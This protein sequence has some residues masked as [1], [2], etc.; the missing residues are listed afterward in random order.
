MLPTSTRVSLFFLLIPS[1]PAE[2]MPWSSVWTPEFVDESL[3][4]LCFHEFCSCDQPYVLR[5]ECAGSRLDLT[6]TLRTSSIVIDNCTLNLEEEVFEAEAQY[7]TISNSTIYSMNRQAFKANV[8][9]G[10]KFL[11]NSFGSCHDRA[12]YGIALA[13]G[14]EIL[15]RGNTYLAFENGCLNLDKFIEDY[16]VDAV[17]VFGVDLL[18]ECHCHLIDQLLNG[19]TS[20][21]LVLEKMLVTETRLANSNQPSHLSYLICFQM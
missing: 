19:T 20:P 6:R 1:L 5:C 9:S 18:Q 17:E 7:L 15:M 3:K 21:T 10:V 8:T 13:K 12:Y 2:I 4:V 14:A 16:D 11:D